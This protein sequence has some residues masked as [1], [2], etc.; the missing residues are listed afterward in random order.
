MANVWARILMGL[1]FVFATLSSPV[2]AQSAPMKA[3]ET[4]AV[5]HVEGMSDACAKAMAADAAKAKP[6]KSAPADHSSGCCS[7]GCNC[8]LSH[9]PATPSLLAAVI[10]APFHAGSAILVDRESQTLVSFH[11]DALIRPPRA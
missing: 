4:P 11:T 9:C 10:T 3:H 7:N 8:P 1:I 2:H 6:H 5:M